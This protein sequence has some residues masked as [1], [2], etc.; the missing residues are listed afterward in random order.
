MLTLFLQLGSNLLEGMNSNTPL[1][2]LHPCTYSLTLVLVLHEIADEYKD[3][4]EKVTRR[5]KT[6]RER[7]GWGLEKTATMKGGVASPADLRQVFGT[8]TEMKQFI[9]QYSHTCTL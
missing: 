9:L 8:V 3:G 4:E 5:K 1:S 6:R 2:H 7:S